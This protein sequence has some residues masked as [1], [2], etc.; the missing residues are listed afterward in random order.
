MS[1]GLD[2]RDNLEQLLQ[3]RRIKTWVRA[4]LLPGPLSLIT[5]VECLCED[6]ECEGLATQITIQAPGQ[7]TRICVIHKPL[8]EV[9][10][11]DFAGLSY[12]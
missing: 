7:S 11:A 6:P 2:I 5:V 9:T 4:R 10:Q 8:A 3:V 1:L 12:L